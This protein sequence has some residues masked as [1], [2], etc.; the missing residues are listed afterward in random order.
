MKKLFVLAGLVILIVPTVV[1]AAV[2]R[3][4]SNLAQGEVVSGNLYMTGSAPVVAGTVQGDLVAAGGTV[5]VTGNV[6]Q[7]ALIA[8][9]NINV[10]G[11]VGGDLRAFGGNIYID[12]VVQGEVFTAGGDIKIGPNAVIN[13][14]LIASG[15]NVQL[16]PA[17][18]VYGN[19]KIASGQDL[20]KNAEANM[21][22]TPKFLQA[23]FLIGQLM[24]ILGL[25]LVAAL[26]FG[27]YPLVTNKL[28]AKTLEKGCIWKNLGLG[29][30]MLLLLPV[31][32]VICLITGVG[33]L[34]GF[35]IIFAFV[36]Y[37]LFGIAFAGIT[38]GGWLH[39]V[40]KKPKKPQIT[41][42]ALIL[43]VI[44]LHIISIIP[45]IGWIIALIFMLITWGGAAR[46]KLE[47]V[48]GIK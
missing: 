31:A 27:F 23:A 39:H 20:E 32:G 30:L 19:K 41:W 34:L 16:N 24:S 9:G 38:F 21:G 12:S 2:I 3:S 17:A 29:L 40:T 45:V 46:M 10:T 11:P 26:S 6:T 14:D 5:V 15:G 18:K 47:L 8:A 37:I 36:L 35:I 48:K 7:D 4:D 1:L 43:G 13:G 42:G 22:G 25:L 28:V 44:L 33:V